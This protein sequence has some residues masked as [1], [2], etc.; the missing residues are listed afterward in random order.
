MNKIYILSLLLLPLLSISAQSF[1][2]EY[3]AQFKSEK[4]FEGAGS[5]EFKKQ[6]KDI[7]SQP[8]KHI[9]TY[10]EGNSVY[11]S[12]PPQ[13]IYDNHGNNKLDVTGMYRNSYKINP[14]KLFKF[15]EEAGAYS[16]KNVQNVESYQYMIPI[17]NKI[18]KLEGSDIILDY[19]CKIIEVELINKKK[20]KV[21]YTEQIPAKTGPLNYF[22]FPGVVLKVETEFMSVQAK[23][24]EKNLAN[25]DLEKMDKNLKVYEAEKL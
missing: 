5:E 23:N 9:L 14:I 8:Q 17:F 22:D 7:A 16:L 15:K 4:T 12:Y 13:M 11:Q 19:Q 20:A 2:I 10:S 1:K 18:Q 25:I 21:W 24:I 6:I 3:E